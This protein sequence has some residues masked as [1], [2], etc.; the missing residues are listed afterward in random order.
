LAKSVRRKKSAE[1]QR[2][3]KNREKNFS[4]KAEQKKEYIK[5][6][7]ACM[8]PISGNGKIIIY[9]LCITRFQ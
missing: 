7:V 2:T 6:I 4:K 9:Y 8:K 3:K 5:K 1:N